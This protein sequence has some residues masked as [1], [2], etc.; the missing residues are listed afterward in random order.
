MNT[1][2]QSLSLSRQLK[3]VL[4]IAAVFSVIELLNILTGRSLNIFGLYP[5]ELLG[6]RGIIFSPFLHGNIWHYGSNVVSLAVFCLLML[7]YGSRRFIWVSLFIMGLTGILVWLFGR[8][9][10]HL[11]ASGVIYGYFGFLLLAGFISGRIKLFLISLVV[12]FFYAGL[13]YGV[14]PN[15]PFVSWESHLFGLVSGLLAAKIWAR[16]H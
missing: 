8:T 2:Y 1:H 3:I 13:L 7:Q 6:L 11:G 12:G 10:M 14:L 9:A 4:V 5:R 16:K 15:R